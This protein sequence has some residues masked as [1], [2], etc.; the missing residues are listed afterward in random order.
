M[1]EFFKRIFRIGKA[2]A[3]AAV[4][5][6]E[7]PI[8]MTEQ[9]LR[10]LQKDLDDSL[11]SLAEVKATA[12][13]SNRDA[14][15]QKQV[16]EDYDAKARALLLKARDGSLEM[17]EAKRLAGE[18][19]AKKEEALAQHQVS[20]DNTAKYNNMA[21]QL[22]IKIDELKAQLNKWTAEL[23][24]LKVR[25]E[26]SKTSA[27]INK[28]LAG[29]DPNDTIALLERMKSKVEEKEALSEAYADMGNSSKSVDAEINKALQGAKSSA[30]LDSLMAELCMDHAPKN[31]PIE[32]KIEEPLRIEHKD[33]SGT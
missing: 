22:K 18:A 12:I 4:E 19:L 9:G 11:Q 31:E 21:D 16:A 23:K 29:I 33:N 13:R 15:A 32:L 7:Q 26:A 27:K 5:S 1:F 8:E 6:L 24:M 10:E 17:E 25:Y 20:T 28:Q 3:N 2:K 30:S 14:M